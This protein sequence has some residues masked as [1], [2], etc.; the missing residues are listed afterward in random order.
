MA[1]ALIAPYAAVF[2]LFVIYPMAYGLWMGRDPA[3]YDQLFSDPRYASSS[4]T[5]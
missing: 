3:L 2:V 1:L 4:S 5:R